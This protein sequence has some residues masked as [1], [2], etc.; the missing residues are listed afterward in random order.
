MGPMQAHGGATHGPMLYHV[1]FNGKDALALVQFFEK[2]PR[3]SNVKTF[4]VLHVVNSTI[5]P[6]TT[7]TQT[8]FSCERMALNERLAVSPYT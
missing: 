4:E 5:V 6:G 1:I 2:N 7:N 3:G 8:E